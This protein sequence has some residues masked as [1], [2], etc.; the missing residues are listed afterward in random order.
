MTWQAPVSR[1][2]H[3]LAWLAV[4]LVA[5]L[6][7]MP[8]SL[9]IETISQ[10]ASSPVPVDAGATPITSSPTLESILVR[11]DEM[12]TPAQRD[13]LAIKL[14][15]QDAFADDVLFLLLSSLRDRCLPEQAHALARMAVAA[16]LPV[17]EGATA[18]LSEETALRPALY[19]LIRHLAATAPCGHPLEIAIGNYRVNVDPARYAAAFPDSYFDP[20]LDAPPSDA[21]HRDLRSSSEDPCTPIAYAALPLQAERAWTCMGL[22]ANLRKRVL[23]TCAA[24]LHDQPAAATSVSL[25]SRL[26]ASLQG[27]LEKLPVMCR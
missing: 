1:P 13:A 15:E 4:L 24:A 10:R 17:L 3:G 2:D 23:A 8:G 5:C 14:H 9:A 12:L 22:R 19:A 26:A 21:D 6:M 20:T 27:E 25:P 11:A 7:V 16:H 18:A